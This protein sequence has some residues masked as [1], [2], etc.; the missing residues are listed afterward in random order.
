M[1]TIPETPSGDQN[2]PLNLG[3]DIAAPL[4]GLTKAVHLLIQHQAELRKRDFEKVMDDSDEC[5]SG[6]D[7]NEHDELLT[8]QLCVTDP[9][10]FTRVKAELGRAQADPA[11]LPFVEN[12]FDFLEQL[13]S[14]GQLGVKA[15]VLIARR[16]V[17]CSIRTD[18]KVPGPQ[19]DRVERE[20]KLELSSTKWHKWWK[21]KT[22]LTKSEQAKFRP[23]HFRPKYF[24]PKRQ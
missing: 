2:K 17:L 5:D 12:A 11:P 9:T 14:A 22:K 23:P 13:V 21:I 18:T 16:L 6:M 15:K 8:E 20:L 19:L 1:C 7:L 3:P 24:P 10:Q 4:K